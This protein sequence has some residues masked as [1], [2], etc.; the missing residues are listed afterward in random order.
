MLPKLA[1]AVALC[2]GI[3]P[4]PTLVEPIGTLVTGVVNRVTPAKVTPHSSVSNPA[5]T[6][7]NCQSLSG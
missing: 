5:A 3:I 2:S 1:V 4:P 7:H 6:K